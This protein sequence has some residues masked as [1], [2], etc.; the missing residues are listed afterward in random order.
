MHI[1]RSKEQ[2]G[3]HVLTVAIALV[4]LVAFTYLNLAGTKTEYGLRRDDAQIVGVLTP[5]WDIGW[6]LCFMVLEPDFHGPSWRWAFA[7]KQEVALFRPLLLAANIATLLSVTLVVASGTEAWVRRYDIRVRVWHYLA[8]IAWLACGISML[9][10]A[11]RVRDSDYDAFWDE[12]GHSE[13]AKRLLYD[14][15][16]AMDGVA[17]GAAWIILGVFFLALPLVIAKYLRAIKAMMHLAV[18]NDEVEVADDRP[19]VKAING[20]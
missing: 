3:L 18:R 5:A 2:K 9:V 1:R 12:Y 17:E 11:E 6:P 19:S 14:D 16:I 7:P 10:A 4:T 13:V 20:N 15:K 8:L